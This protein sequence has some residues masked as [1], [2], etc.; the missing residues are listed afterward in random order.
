MLESVT[1]TG[2]DDFVEPQDL[3][4]LSLEF[5]F[6]EWGILLHESKEG[7]NP[8]FPSK[9]WIDE[10]VSLKNK[11][12]NLAGHICGSWVRKLA[13]N[14]DDSVFKERP[15]FL[16]YFQRI[17]LNFSCYDVAPRMVALLPKNKK[18]ILQ[19][20]SKGIADKIKLVDLSRDKMCDGELSCLTNLSILFD[21]SGG[22]GISPEK[23]PKPIY[24]VDCGYAGGLGP[25]NLNEQILKIIET[26]GQQTVY[27]V[28]FPFAPLQI[29]VPFWIDM[30]TSVRTNDKFDLKKVRKCLEICKPWVSE[31]LI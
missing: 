12:I 9:Q 6:V 1:I 17:Q 21:R 10:L 16:E 25:D 24:N 18:F 15:E 23:W 29:D 14:L 3:I 13:V 28:D 8:R 19:I 2:A 22:K 26:V 27:E 5:P 20:G 7:L 4:D 31:D 30:E 11:R